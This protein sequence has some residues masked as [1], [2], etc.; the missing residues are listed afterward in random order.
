MEILGNA[1]KNSEET[2]YDR[3]KKKVD[4]IKGFYSHLKAYIIVNV[5][6]FILKANIVSYIA[7]GELDTVDFHK[8]LDWNTYITPVLW[9]IGLALHGI[10]VFHGKIGLIKNW[11]ERK[12]RAYMEKEDSDAEKF[13]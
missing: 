3:A 11:E 7:G 10:Y 1:M 2:K 9:G 12:I 8:M 13:N 4:A 6:L 5:I